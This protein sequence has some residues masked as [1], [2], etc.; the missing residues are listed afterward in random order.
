M[1]N[2]QNALV[3]LSLRE[4][5]KRSIYALVCT[6]LGGGIIVAMVLKPVHPVSANYISG[7]PAVTFLVIGVYQLACFSKK[8][9]EPMRDQRFIANLIWIVTLLAFPGLVIVGLDIKMQPNGFVDALLPGLIG[10]A[11]LMV[12]AVYKVI[13]SVNE[14]ELRLRERILATHFGEPKA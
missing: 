7:I 8:Q 3:K 1:N 6:V 2:T 10:L 13:A 9:F 4:K 14:V 12:G 11:I 5:V